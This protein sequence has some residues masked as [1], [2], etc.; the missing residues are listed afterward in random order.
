MLVTVED[1][2]AVSATRTFNPFSSEMFTLPNN[3]KHRAP[4]KALTER[5]GINLQPDPDNRGDQNP[6]R[7]QIQFD[8]TLFPFPV[9]A[10]T[11]GDRLGDVTGVVGYSFGNFEVNALAPF[12]ITPSGLGLQTTSLV[13]ERNRVTVASYNVLNL[14]PL[15]SDDNQRATLASQ[16]VTN[17]ASPDVIASRRSR[18][19]A[20][21]QTTA[22]PTPPRRSKR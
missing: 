10:I 3:G 11:V 13:G 17:L 12:S 16:I 6:E 14:S 4:K 15:S 8:A 20:E 2:V 21:R 5:G 18:T 9:P 1:P 22:R 19:T 7:V